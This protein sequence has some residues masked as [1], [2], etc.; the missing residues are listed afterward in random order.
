MTSLLQVVLLGAA[1][2]LEIDEATILVLHFFWFPFFFMSLS[3]LS[4]PDAP[5]M[6]YMPISWGG[7]GG[8]CRHIW[9][10]WSVWVS[11]FVYVFLKPE[12]L[13][14]LLVG[15]RLMRCSF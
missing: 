12:L 1:P 9:H 15:S 5:C 7:L 8:Q 4:F 6:E 2:L 14:D 13:D 10:T 11:F 3:F